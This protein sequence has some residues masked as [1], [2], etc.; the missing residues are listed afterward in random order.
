MDKIFVIAGNR[1]QANEWIKGNLTKRHNAGETDISW[2]DYVIVSE[3][4]KLRGIQDPHGVFVGTWK[5]RVDLLQI[6]NTLRLNS[7]NNA[8]VHTLYMK[9]WKHSTEEQIISKNAHDMAQDIDKQVIQQ[10][11]ANLI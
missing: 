4:N 11:I 9:A 2:S 10:T 6:M 5:Q 1:E 7:P 3:V 8:T